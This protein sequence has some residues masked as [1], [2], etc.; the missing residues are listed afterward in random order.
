MEQE[1]TRSKLL[2][3]A[4][5]AT[6][7][8]AT[9]AVART[10]HAASRHIAMDAHHLRQR[11]VIVDPGQATAVPPARYKF[12]GYAPVPPAQNRNLDPSNYGGDLPPEVLEQRSGDGS[13]AP[14]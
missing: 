6:A 14:A 9:P 7:M 1:M 4:L 12:P 3:A 11:D 5:V 8:L 2:S 13:R 10:D